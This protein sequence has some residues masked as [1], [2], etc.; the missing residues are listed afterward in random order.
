MII[1]FNTPKLVGSIGYKD[2]CTR[3]VITKMDASLV[4]KRILYRDYYI[5]VG[6][7]DHIEV[8]PDVTYLPGSNDIS[9]LPVEDVLKES[10][11][12]FNTRLTSFKGFLKT[13]GWKEEPRKHHWPDWM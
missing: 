7:F 1:K 11:T 12:R 4:I 9:E 10:F 8:N 13:L 3:L 2:G 6:S 5:E